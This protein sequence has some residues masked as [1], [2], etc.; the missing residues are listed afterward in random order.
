MTERS[1]I[2]LEVKLE[3][4][5]SIGTYELTIQADALTHMQLAEYFG[6]I[7]SGA[8]ETL[9]DATWNQI[10]TVLRQDYFHGDVFDKLVMLLDEEYKRVIRTAWKH[11]DDRP[12]LPL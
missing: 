6:V 2:T 5:E 11:S 9:Y 1:K 8:I 4:T 3:K 10:E 12:E 7:D